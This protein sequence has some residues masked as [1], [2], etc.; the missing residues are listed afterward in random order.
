LGKNPV[1]H[2]KCH[3]NREQKGHV[4]RSEQR[5]VRGRE[6][7]TQK[8]AEIMAL[9]EDARKKWALHPKNLSAIEV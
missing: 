1:P 2:W 6:H 5:T 9:L 8:A 4:D 7:R 3:W